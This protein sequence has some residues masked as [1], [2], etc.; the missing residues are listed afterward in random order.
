MA[1]SMLS[2]IRWHQPNAEVNPLEYLNLVRWYIHWRNGYRMNNYIDKELDK[3][4][5]EYRAGQESIQTKAVVDLVIQAYVSHGKDGLSK[6]LDPSF[7]R[8][9]VRQIRLFF[10]AGHDSTSST[11]CYLV[12]L[13]S[14]NPASLAKL[15]AEHDCVFGPDFSNTSA[16]LSS[17]P[18][19]IKSLPYTQAVIKETLRLFPPAASTRAGKDHVS[20]TSGIGTPLP[21]AD[22]IVLIVHTELHRSPK[23]W[24]RPNDFIPERWLVSSEH[25]LCP[26]RGAWRAFEHGPRNCIA[27][28]LVMME[29]SVV[30]VMIMREFDFQNCYNDFDALRSGQ[31]KKSYWGERA[32][33]VQ[34]GAAHPVDGYP[35]RVFVR[36]RE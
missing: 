20:L 34:S 22:A 25:E 8:F 5:D 10:F 1:D 28:D 12:H 23:Y 35:C 24:P 30:L 16:I 9:A 33:Q 18:Q 19:L 36:K 14:A 13:L 31:A 15:R 11:I 7:R 29:L 32:Y 26:R 4:Y 3:R 17:K 2:Q 27:Q 21:T 6:R